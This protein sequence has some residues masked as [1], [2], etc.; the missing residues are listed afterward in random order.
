MLFTSV[1]DPIRLS[2]LLIDRRAK[3]R[4][5]VAR[6]IHFV[7]EPAFGFACPQKIKAA[8]QDHKSQKSE[9]ESG[10]NVINPNAENKRQEIHH[11]RWNQDVFPVALKN[12]ETSQI[13]KNIWSGLSS[14]HCV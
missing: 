3:V 1:C 5:A 8:E 11:R 12:A 6:R 14:S 2:E 7:F 10:G 4:P 9:R 13:A